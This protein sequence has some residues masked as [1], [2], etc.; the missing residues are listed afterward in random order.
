MKGNVLKMV[1]GYTMANYDGALPAIDDCFAYGSMTGCDEHCPVLI[2][3]KCKL[4]DGDN[5]DL[6]AKAK[7][8]YKIK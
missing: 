8:I 4:Q 3:G 1:F 6:Y 5:A 7:E 2:A